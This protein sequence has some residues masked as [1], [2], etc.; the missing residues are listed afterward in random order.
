MNS[1]SNATCFIIILEHT[2]LVEIFYDKN[3]GG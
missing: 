2:M 3:Y 1:P